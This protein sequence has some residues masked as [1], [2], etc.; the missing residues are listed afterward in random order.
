LRARERY[1]LD[2]FAGPG[3]NQIEETGEVIDG[4][5]LI[6]LRAGP[7]YFTRLFWVD[8]SKRN[9]ASLEEH[10]RD[11]PDRAVEIFHGDA[12]LRV[13]DILGVL[14][15][16]A[17]VFCFLDPR[18]GELAWQTIAKLA[19]HKPENKV[20]LFI[21]FAYNQGLVRLLPHDPTKLH[22]ADVLDRVMP[23]PIGWRRVYQQRIE[24]NTRPGEFRLAFLDEYVRGLKE[25]LGYR[26]VPAPRLVPTPHGRPLYF[27][28][29][30]SDHPAGGTIMQWCLKHVQDSRPQK[31][32]LSYE[33][34]Y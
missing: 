34:R 31:S 22:H 10:R 6:A 12:N 14:P 11:Y 29:F 13:D 8:A 32:F 15:R 16:N 7:P 25:Q 19:R 24:G 28:V 20:E 18:G 5:P 23:E 27:M 33:Q 1:Y 21:L 4:S 2:L 3:Q 9:V 30:A 26:Y 17:P